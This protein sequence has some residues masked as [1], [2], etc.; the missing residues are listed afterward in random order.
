MRY[1]LCPVFC[2]AD[3]RVGRKGGDLASCGYGKSGVNEMPGLREAFGRLR[4]V[5]YIEW[6]LLALAAAAAA[7]MLT[8]RSSSPEAERTELEIR[9]E[10]VLSCVEGAGKVRVLVSSGDTAAVFSQ[11]EERRTGVVVVAEG[12]ENIRVALELERA[13]QALLGVNADQIEILDMKE[14][15]P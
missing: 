13:V 9:M 8:G 10:S 14:E 15:S 5:R 4:G 12:A 7:I 1:W 3:K 11:A 2:S 6:I